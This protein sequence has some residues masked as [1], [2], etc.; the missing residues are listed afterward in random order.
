MTCHQQSFCQ[1]CHEGDNLDRLTHPHNFEFTHALAAQG[2]ER[3]CAVCHTQRSF[4]IDCHRDNLVLPHNHPSGWTNQ[5]DGGRHRL[6]AMSDLENCMA[7]H[8]QNADQ[9]CQ[10]CHGG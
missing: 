7:C 10:P 1:D 2:K 5:I 9:I 6:E 4:C 3:E 8:E